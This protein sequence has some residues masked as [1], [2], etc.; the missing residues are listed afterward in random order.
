MK[1]FNSSSDYRIASIR[2]AFVE[3]DRILPNS[4]IYDLTHIQIAILDSRLIED[5]CILT[6]DDI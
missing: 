5:L 3:G 6:M 1:T 2:S 4:A